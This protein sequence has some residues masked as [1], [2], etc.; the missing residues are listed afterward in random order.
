MGDGVYAALAN[1]AY[2][3]ALEETGAE[4]FVLENDARAAGVLGRLQSAGVL[5]M[6]GFVALSERFERQM[7]WY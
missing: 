3:R 2:C 7:P 4:I 1:T 6:D 5:D